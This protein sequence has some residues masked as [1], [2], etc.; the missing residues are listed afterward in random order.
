ML[1]PNRKELSDLAGMTT[2]TRENVISAA[3]LV[4][5]KDIKEA[6][7]ISNYAA[8]LQVS[9]V[10]TSIVYPEEVTEA[11][12]HENRLQTDKVLDFYKEQGLAV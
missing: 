3:E 11:M 6:M 2:D 4:F 5:G 7:V 9:K 12:N 8:G 1:K 10:G